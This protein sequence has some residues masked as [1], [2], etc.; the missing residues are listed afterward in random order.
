MAMRHPT[1]IGDLRGRRDGTHTV[2]V[3]GT[4][5][6]TAPCIARLRI[7][8]FAPTTMLRN[9]AC[10]PWWGQRGAIGQVGRCHELGQNLLPSTF[11]LRPSA[12]LNDVSSRLIG[13]T[14][15]VSHPLTHSRPRKSWVGQDCRKHQAFAPSQDA[16]RPAWNHVRDR[17]ARR[18]RGSATG[19]CA[20]C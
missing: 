17:V 19:Q 8:A 14:G 10:R 2:S 9:G 5:F 15:P 4:I 11:G 12:N 18:K 1:S 6:A 20:P 7:A 13:V 16:W 3:G